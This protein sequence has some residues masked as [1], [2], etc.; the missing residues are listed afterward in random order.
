MATAIIG[1]GGIASAIARQ[2]ASGGE[3]LQLSSPDNE[4]ARK[5][6]AAIGA[7]AVVA[8]DNRSALQGVNA[9]VLALRYSVLKDAID[10]IADA[11]RDTSLLVPSNP[12]GVV[13]AQGKVMRLGR[14]ADRVRTPTESESGAVGADYL[15]N[16]DRREIGPSGLHR[17][18]D[19][20]KKLMRA[21][22]NQ[23]RSIQRSELVGT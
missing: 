16:L 1:T 2:L 4:S 17:A 22:P 3:V 7:A 6:T 20:F 5:L 14:L 8:V 9:L 13:D 12:V 10:E 19:Q 11:L 18:I 23:L 15:F 21:L